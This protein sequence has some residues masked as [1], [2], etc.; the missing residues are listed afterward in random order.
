MPYFTK[1]F[2]S[3]KAAIEATPVVATFL[4]FKSFKLVM[5]GRTITH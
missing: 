5:F 4:P 2:L 1:M 3:M